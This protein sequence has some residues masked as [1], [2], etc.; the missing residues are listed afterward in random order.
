MK[1]VI[2]AMCLLILTGCQIQQNL[3]SNSS[4][5]KTL[6]ATTKQGDT[7][8]TGKITQSGEVFSLT[9]GDGKQTEVDSYKID[10]SEYVD[11]EVTIV[12]QYSGETLFIG[13]I[14]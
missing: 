5:M 2:F 7:T 11:Q 3:N 1:Y 12:G 6:D 4:E 10:L 13:E 8:L 14:Q 9:D